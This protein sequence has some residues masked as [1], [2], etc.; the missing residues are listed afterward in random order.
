[1]L[2]GTLSPIACARSLRHAP[3]AA[4]FASDDPLPGFFDLPLVAARLFKRRLRRGDRDP[5]GALQSAK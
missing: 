2:A 5:V 1:M 3:A 4:V